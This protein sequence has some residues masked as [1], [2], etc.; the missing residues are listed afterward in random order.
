LVGADQNQARVERIKLIF[1]SL[2]V[3]EKS[4][5]WKINQLREF[6][7]FF[8]KNVVPTKCFIPLDMATALSVYCGHVLQSKEKWLERAAP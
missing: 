6:L 7:S 1:D 2:R 5:L 4:A 8:A 3:C